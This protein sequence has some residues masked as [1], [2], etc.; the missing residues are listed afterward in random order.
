M[1]GIAAVL[2]FDG[3]APNRAVVEHMGSLLRHRGPDD[4][5]SFVDR[6]VAFAH[7]RL[8]IIDL[9]TG[10]QPMSVGPHTIVFNGEIYNYV[11][12]REELTRAGHAFR[13]TSDTEV[14]LRMYAEHGPSFVRRL[15]GMFAFLIYDAER[16]TVLAARDHFGI[17]PLYFAEAPDGALL[18]ASEIKALLAYPGMRAAP[19][20]GGVRDYL[21]FQFVLG[22][23]TMFAGI[24]KVAPA[25]MLEVALSSGAR[26]IT[27][28]WSPDFGIDRHHNEDYF[29]ERT[30]ELLEDSVRLQLRSDVPVGAYLSGGLDSSIVASLAARHA[31]IEAF[32][33]VFPEGP[34]FDESPYAREVAASLGIRLHEIVPSEEEFRALLPRLVWHMDEPAAG[35]GLF[36]QFVVS[37][38]ARQH[39]KVALGGQGGDEIF[40]GYARYLV[41]YLEQALKGAIFE[42]NVE[43]SHIVSLASIVPNL[44]ALR[45]YVPM[46]RQFWRN[47]AFEDMD[48]RY[49]RLVDRAGGAVSLFMPEFREAYNPE[50]VFQRFAT[51]FNAPDTPSYFNRM[52]HFDV[53]NGLPALLQVEDRVSMAHSLESR[54]PLLDYRLVE[55]AAT[56][57]ARLKFEGG[58]LKYLLKRAAGDLVPPAVLARKDKMGFPVPLQ[59]WFRGNSRDFVCDILL[60]ERARQRGIFDPAA[61][62]A[63]LDVERP[64]S[65]QVWGLLNLELWFQQ[66]IDPPASTFGQPETAGFGGTMVARS[67]ERAARARQKT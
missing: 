42:T 18:F 29:V 39:V 60:S 46:L 4:E 23:R 48:R 66:F 3:T 8:A 6:G 40:G 63:Q 30:R 50:D 26:R 43:G 34:T 20:D 37:G 31:P 36:P 49:F 16:R 67:T 35:P 33:A 55:L 14:L 65:R 9:L 7:R 54:V 22:D 28:Y 24:R 64:F 51:V 45:E 19:D 62:E 56:M 58:Q 11:E 15:N 38:L 47:G 44:P 25:H 41:A 59:R 12:L 53:M 57:P 5:G 13:T 2:R 52:T 21:T 1:C 10:H 17:K 61:V 32:T 27:H